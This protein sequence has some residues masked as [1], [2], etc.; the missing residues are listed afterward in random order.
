MEPPRTGEARR[1][2]GPKLNGCDGIV[3]DL[4][5]TFEKLLTL[6]EQLAINIRDYWEI[7]CPQKQIHEVHAEIDDA[8][9]ARL[10]RVIEP[11]LVRS[12]GIVKDQF[13][14]IDLTDHV[15]PH[16]VADLLHACGE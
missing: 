9:A 6:R 4:R 12:I 5:Q 14:G 7:Q 8:T 11:G 2:A 3:R 1:L 15:L 16:E 13:G 10:S